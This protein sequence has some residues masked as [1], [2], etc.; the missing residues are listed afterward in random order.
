MAS[1]IEDEEIV[2]LERVKHTVVADF[3][4]HVVRRAVLRDMTAVKQN[5]EG[6]SEEKVSQKWES[7]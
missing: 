7:N 4:A 6:G 5:D 3:W 1:T 2:D